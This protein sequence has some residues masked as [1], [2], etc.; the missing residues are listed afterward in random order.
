[1]TKSHFLVA[2]VVALVS[3][4]SHGAEEALFPVYAAALAGDG[5]KA[6][7]ELS[8]IDVGV[9]DAKEAARAKCIRD[10][11]LAPPQGEALPPLSNNLL[12][13]YR[14]YWQDSMMRRVTRE[15]AESG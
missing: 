8:S 2:V 13:A 12:L 4:P 3:A 15:E 10:A 7:A 6:L 14:S 9:L 5:V 11:L 1:M